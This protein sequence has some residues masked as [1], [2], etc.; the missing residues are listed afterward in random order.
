MLWRGC[1]L[2]IAC[3]PLALG[4]D[5]P[6]DLHFEVASVKSMP[7]LP[8]GQPS[9]GPPFQ[10]GPG[11]S[12]PERLT[13]R[14]ELR[15]LIWRA[16]GIRYFQV[17]GPAWMDSARYEVLAKVPPGATAEQVNVMLQNLLAERFELKLHHETRILQVYVLTVDKNGSKMQLASDTGVTR[18]AAPGAP[19][20]PDRDGYV[21][22]PSGQTGVIGMSRDGHLRLSGYRATIAKL[23]PFLQG[24]DHPL[25]DRTGLTGEYNF[26]L[27]YASAR[28]T[29]DDADPAPSIFSALQEQ[30]GLRL[31]DEKAP[32]DVLVIDGADRE[33]LPN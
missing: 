31:K 1:V 5:A 4:Q 10:G 27:D 22:L 24:L 32:M 9:G 2:L 6:A 33:P 25:V 30:L 29:T 11:T 14:M 19:I 7:A 17:F 21:P 8:A 13:I 16:Y 20:V 23:I 28:A 3:I 15:G 18:Q 26:R 12:D